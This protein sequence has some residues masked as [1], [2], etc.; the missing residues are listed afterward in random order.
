MSR[1]FKDPDDPVMGTRAKSRDHMPW[2]VTHHV[3]HVD[4]SW[5]W[6]IYIP[7]SPL[8]FFSFLSLSDSVGVLWVSH[9]VFNHLG[10]L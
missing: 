1:T 9:G 7:L 10:R 5:G 3:T 8:A 6:S 4:G 2:L